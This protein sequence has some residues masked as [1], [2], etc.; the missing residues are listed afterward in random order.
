M[1]DDPDDED[2]YDCPIRAKKPGILRKPARGLGPGGVPY[3][4]IA[5]RDSGTV[6]QSQRGGVVRGRGRPPNNP[7]IFFNH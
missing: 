7:G 5:S 3:S 2:Y 6:L 4:M 1:L